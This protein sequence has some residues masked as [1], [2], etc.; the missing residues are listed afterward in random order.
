[1]LTSWGSRD[2]ADLSLGF[3]ISWGKGAGEDIS[4]IGSSHL[5]SIDCGSVNIN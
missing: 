2:V 3:L 5:D 1:M 4:T